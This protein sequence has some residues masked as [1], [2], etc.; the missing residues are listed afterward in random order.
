M[1]PGMLEII[2]LPRA[3]MGTTAALEIIAPLPPRWHP[4]K[5]PWKRRH[6]NNA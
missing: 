5:H 3:M 2:A 1:Q 4:P 6:R